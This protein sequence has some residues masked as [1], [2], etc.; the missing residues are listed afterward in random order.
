MT[1]AEIITAL[2]PLVPGASYEEVP[3]VDFA[4]I[5]VPAERLVETCRVL[6]D[7]DPLQYSTIIEITAADYLPRQPRFE[8]VYHLLSIARRERL[9]LKVRVAEGAALPTVQGV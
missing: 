6:R 9:R 8:V 2:S 7:A 4:T 1:A 5:Y 3:S